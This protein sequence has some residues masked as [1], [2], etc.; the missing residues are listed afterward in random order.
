MNDPIESRIA[1]LERSLRRTRLIACIAVGTLIAL[2]LIAM[3][4]MTSFLRADRV[5]ARQ[6]DLVDDHGAVVM[7]LR[8]DDGGSLAM[9]DREGDINLALGE[10]SGS[11]RMVHLGD[12]GRRGWGVMGEIDPDDRAQPRTR[13][14]DGVHATPVAALQGGVDLRPLEKATDAQRVTARE[15]ARR[16]WVYV[17]PR[18]KSASA[19]WGRMDRRATWFNGYWK[20]ETSGRV[21]STT[22]IASDAFAG[23]GVE[24]DEWRYGAPFAAPSVIQWL[25]SR[26]GGVEPK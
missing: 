26:E 24:V 6:V 11:R 16:G 15:L 2:P 10:R 23:D 21:S 18:P 13:A 12:A 4:P 17:M 5:E 1:A 20:N 22:P 7:S 9:Y 8:G 14:L 19:A 25:C 3:G